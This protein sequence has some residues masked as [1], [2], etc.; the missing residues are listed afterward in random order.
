MIEF[1]AFIGT[2]FFTVDMNMILYDDNEA[3][4]KKILKV[5]GKVKKGG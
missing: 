3:P 1:R 2:L 5:E 4:K